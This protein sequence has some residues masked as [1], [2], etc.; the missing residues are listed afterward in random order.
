MSAEPCT[1]AGQVPMMRKLRHARTAEFCGGLARS[2]V[3]SPGLVGQVSFTATTPLVLVMT[4]LWGARVGNCGDTG[5]ASTGSWPRRPSLQ[6]IRT[7]S[8]RPVSGPLWPRRGGGLEAGGCRVPGVL[9]GVGQRVEPPR[10]LR[11]QVP[12]D[13]L[14]VGSRVGGDCED[15]TDQAITALPRHSQTEFPGLWD[16]LYLHTLIPFFDVCMFSATA[17]VAGNAGQIPRAKILGRARCPSAP[18]R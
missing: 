1:G 2:T 6:L 5:G 18:P 3:F 11:Q 9:L 4:R 17:R 8:C 7:N 12:D 13:Q 14:P 15:A 10:L 16:V